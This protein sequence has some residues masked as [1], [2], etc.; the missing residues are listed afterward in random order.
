MCGIAGIVD[1]HP[2]RPGG[3]E[4]IEAMLG[5]LAHRGPDGSGIAQE[6]PALLGH[7]RLAVIDL[8]DRAAQP[9]R[10]RC[11]AGSPPVWIVF[12]GEIYNYRKLRE[13]LKGRGHQL[14][15]DSDTEAILHLYEE[16]G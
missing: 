6:G 11:A 16:E 4:E 7:R 8:S 12:N 14:H 9:M 15:S 13:G 2:G 3:V 10:L 5:L 1:R